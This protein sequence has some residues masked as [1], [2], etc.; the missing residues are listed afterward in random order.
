MIARGAKAV[1]AMTTRYPAMKYHGSGVPVTMR[2]VP[3]AT[4][5]ATPTAT[6]R[7]SPQGLSAPPETSCALIATAINAGSARVVAKPIA[8]AKT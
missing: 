1:W 8:A 7:R 6:A 4:P 5:M 2:N 3:I